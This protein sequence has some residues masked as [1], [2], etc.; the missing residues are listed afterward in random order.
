MTV[1]SKKDWISMTI[2]EQLK[3]V[4]VPID[5]HESDLYAKRTPES[6]AII[7]AYEFRGIVTTFISQ[8]DKTVWYDIPFAYDR[9]WE[10]VGA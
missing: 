9:F 3:A 10:K 6:Q 1:I 7:A 5:S 2:Y 8:I 4:G